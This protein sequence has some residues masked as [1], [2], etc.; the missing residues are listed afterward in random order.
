MSSQIITEVTDLGQS[1]GLQYMYSIMNDSLHK[2]L[3]F[4][5]EVLKASIPMTPSKLTV[6]SP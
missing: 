5:S 6:L 1:M 3:L 4:W 2:C